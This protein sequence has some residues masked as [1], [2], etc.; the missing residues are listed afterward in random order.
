MVRC[1][2]G[3]KGV[4]VLGLVAGVR[5]EKKKEADETGLD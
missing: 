3:E 1:W 4:C 5:G 2:L